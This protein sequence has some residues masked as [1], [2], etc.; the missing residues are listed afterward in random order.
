MTVSSS[1]ISVYAMA[2]LLRILYLFDRAF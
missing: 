1:G 2:K